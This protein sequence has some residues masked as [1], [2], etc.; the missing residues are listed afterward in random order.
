MYTY[1]EDAVLCLEGAGLKREYIGLWD[2]PPPA[3][4]SSDV[5]G[6]SLSTADKNMY[7][8]IMLNKIKAKTTKCDQIQIKFLWHT[9]H[10]NGYIDY[11]DMSRRP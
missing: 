6:K 2:T 7:N 9:E 11:G 10:S 4:S 8:V 1:V 3:S 5:N